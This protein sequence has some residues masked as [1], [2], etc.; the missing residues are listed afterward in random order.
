PDPLSICFFVNS[1]SEAND[2]AL[3]LA[4]A[5]TSGKNVI[6]VE[7]GYHGHLISLIDV[8]PYKFDGPGGEGLADHVEMVTMPDG[9][10]GKYKYNEPD[11]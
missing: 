4:Q 3:R 6:T 7:G 2:L 1:G 10:R 11:L 5:Y 9:Y 8:S